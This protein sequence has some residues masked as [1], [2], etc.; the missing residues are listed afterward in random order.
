MP[1]FKNSMNR[2][3]TKALFIEF[4]SESNVPTDQYAIYTLQEEDR[5][6]NGKKFLSVYRLFLE[7]NDPTGYTF[8]NNYLGS[9]YH[10]QLLMRAPWFKEVID[11]VLLE[12]EVRTRSDALK[13]IIKDSKNPNSKSQFQASKFLLEK[14]WVPKDSPV[15]RPTKE[16]I[17]EEAEKLVLEEQ[18]VEEAAARILN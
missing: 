5:E 18:E 15:G 1:V 17:K 7:C 2:Y 14:G 3:L 13:S 16:R 4:D 6:V 9:W 10:Y 8:A 11:K 12:L